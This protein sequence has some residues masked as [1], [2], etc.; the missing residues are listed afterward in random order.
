MSN[1]S[2]YFKVSASIPVIL[3]FILISSSKISAQNITHGDTVTLGTGFAFTWV[4]TDAQNTPVRIGIS[5]S[6]S[7]ITNPVPGGKIINFPATASDSLFKHTL[8]GYAPSGHGPT[9]VY[10]VPHYDFHFY[11]ITSQERETIPQE[12]DNVPIPPAFM[13]ERFV[14][15]EGFFSVFQMGVHFVDSLADELHG[16]P[17]D[18][19]LIYGFYQAKMIFIEPMITIDFL[20]TQPDTLIPIVQP[21][22]YQKTAYYPESYVIR[23]NQQ[24]NL[25][26]III[27]DFVLRNGVTSTDNYAD[28]RLPED[29]ILYQNYP[30][31]FNPSTTIR[32]GLN[33]ESSVS[34][35]V[36]NTLGEL[37]DVLTEEV[38]VP[39]THSINW[40]PGAEISSG[41]YFYKMKA[42]SLSDGKS[43]STSRKML[44][45]R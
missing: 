44:M 34:I 22:A 5:L 20:L 12:T 21:A 28:E 25:F 15:I 37:V 31:P 40:N 17:F 8:F 19:T 1:G 30:N 43:Y 42:V 36:F 9:G 39:G 27:T 32:Y 7:A 38:K 13:P 45:L 10:N 33:S 4:E 14:P 41:I 6:Q 23:Y 24:N 11:M 3:F 26:E 29:Y 16:S 18:E 2:Y 35:E